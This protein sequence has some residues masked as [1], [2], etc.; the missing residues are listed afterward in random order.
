MGRLKGTCIHWT[1]KQR[2]NSGFGFV[3]DDA[4][5]KEYRVRWSALPEPAATGSGI[6]GL[7]QGCEVEF[8]LEDTEDGK[9]RAVRVTGPEGAALPEVPP[10]AKLATGHRTGVCLSWAAGKGYGFL[11]DAETREAIFVHRS[12]LQMAA[13]GGIPQ[14]AAGQ[15]VEFDMGATADGKACAENVTGPEGALLAGLPKAAGGE[16]RGAPQNA[17]GAKRGQRGRGNGGRGGRGGDRG[18]PRAA[19][20]GGARGG[21]RGGSREGRDGEGRGRSGGR[22]GRG[23]G[24]GGEGRGGRGRGSA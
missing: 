7:V 14:L 15:A 24:R 20:R 12:A 13:D 5:K 2:K 18:G 10:P 9:Q 21:A 1:E 6:R 22:G 11:T 4:T 23:G 19:G 3:V 16:K 8:E 17:A